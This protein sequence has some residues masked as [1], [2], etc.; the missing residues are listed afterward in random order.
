MHQR[1]WRALF[2]MVLAGI[3][4]AAGAA[5][6]NNDTALRGHGGPVWAVGFSPEGDRIVSGSADDTVRVRD[7]AS[8]EKL[9]V[10]RGHGAD[11]NAVGFSPEGDRI[12]SGSSDSTIRV[13]DA[14]GGEEFLVLHGHEGTVWAAGFSPEGDRIVAASH[15][16]TVL[17]E[18]PLTI[19]SPSGE[20][21]AIGEQ[22][23]VLRGHEGTVWAA[24][25]SPEGNRIVS[26]SSDN[27]VRV[28][29][30]A[31]GAELLVL[32]GHEA[33]V[34]AAG[35]SPAGDRIVSGSDDRT[36]RVTWIGRNK[37]ELI[38]TARA[39]LPRELTDEERRR[40]YLATE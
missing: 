3:Y 31:S 20:N 26:G 33:A 16:R 7:T 4:A 38:E 10:L 30:V 13:W 34:W 28:W 24:G 8:G 11:V 2:I 9:L 1:A 36:V 40:F 5:I 17:S 37:E 19:R 32:R 25:F 35:F 22:L 6:A 14:I 15:T 12:V 23:L 29:E 27:T 39:R 21:P 18:D